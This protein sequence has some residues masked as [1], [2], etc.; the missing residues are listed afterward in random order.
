MKLEQIAAQLKHLLE[1]LSQQV[2]VLLP[3]K[4][5]ELLDG[6]SI[7][8]VC[9]VVRHLLP[10][11][12]LVVHAATSASP[13][14]SLQAAQLSLARETS[15]IAGAVKQVLK[16]SCEEQTEHTTEAAGLGLLLAQNPECKPFLT[17]LCNSQRE[18]LERLLPVMK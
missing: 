1:A 9:V 5:D 8:L 12:R 2:L 15:A 7:T 17:K 14:G 16:L 11:L 3:S 13:K 10:C 6:S 18:T 4:D